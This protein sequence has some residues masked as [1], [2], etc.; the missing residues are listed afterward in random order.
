MDP[1]YIPF[2]TF[3]NV[4][5]LHIEITLFETDFSNSIHCKVER[6][7]DPPALHFY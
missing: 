3:V 2:S 4:E 1:L 5:M 7:T 6:Y